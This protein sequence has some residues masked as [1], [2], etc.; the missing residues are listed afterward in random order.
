MGCSLTSKHT[1]TSFLRGAQ[2]RQNRYVIP[3]GAQSRQNTHVIPTGRPDTSKHIRH[4][5]EESCHV[6]THV[7][8]KPDEAM[9]PASSGRAHDLQIAPFHLTDH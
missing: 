4:S 2:S 7:S 8:M 1:H 3:T 9:T 6:K 5:Y